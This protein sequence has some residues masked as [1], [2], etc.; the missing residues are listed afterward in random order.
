MN[1]QQAEYFF[2]ISSFAGLK[3]IYSLK[4][5]F[6][7]QTAFDRVEFCKIAFL[8]SPDYFFGFIIACAAFGVVSFNHKNQ[9]ITVTF[10]DP[11]LSRDI[12]VKLKEKAKESPE[13]LKDIE[14]IE[15]YFK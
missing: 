14:S 1:E 9:I 2:R 10:I 3:A 15:T 11:I 13:W 5:S 7:K 4:L 12:E 8:A 6:E